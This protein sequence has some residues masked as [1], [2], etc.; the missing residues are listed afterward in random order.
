V[1]LKAKKIPFC[2]CFY[3]LAFAGTVMEKSESGNRDKDAGSAILVRAGA[4]SSHTA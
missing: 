2:C 1:K 3:F 4:N